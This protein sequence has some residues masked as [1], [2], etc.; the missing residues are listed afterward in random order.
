MN[1]DRRLRPRQNR[2]ESGFCNTNN[3]LR[4]LADICTCRCHTTEM[5]SPPM[6]ELLLNFPGEEARAE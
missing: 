3:H 4:C 6:D 1:T 5:T 2:Y